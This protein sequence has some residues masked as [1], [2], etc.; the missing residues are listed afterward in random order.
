MRSRRGSM[1]ALRGSSSAVVGGGDLAGAFFPA[2][3]RLIP[4]AMEGRRQDVTT[5]VPRC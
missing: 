2:A 1:E 3:C 5:R 4:P